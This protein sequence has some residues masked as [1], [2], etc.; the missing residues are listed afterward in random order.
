MNEPIM[1]TPQEIVNMVI[2]ISAGVVTISTAVTLIF[3][4]LSK[5]K[6]PETKQDSRLDAAERRLDDIDRK[7][8]M[9]KKRLDNIEYGNEVTQ[10][11]LLALLNYSLNS[12][13]VE[14]L[15]VA[16]KKLE[17]YLISRGEKVVS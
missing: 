11:A 10:E 16:K 17:G 9:D 3:K 15:K 13:E 2:A 14:G 6:E 1:L 7:L 4:W 5:V 12:E 8:A